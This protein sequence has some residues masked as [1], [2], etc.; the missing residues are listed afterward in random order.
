[1]GSQIPCNGNENMPTLLAVAPLVRLP[2]ARLEHLVGMDACVLPE[3]RPRKGRDQCVG[4]MTQRKVTGNQVRRRTD[5]LLAVKGVEDRSEDVFGTDR[6]VIEPL[7][8]LAGWRR[9]RDIQ[10][11]GEIER[12]CPMEEA[13][14]DLDGVR[15][16]GAN[17][18]ES[19]MNGV[20]VGEDVV[21]SFPI[22]MLVGGAEARHSE[23][24]RISERSTEVGRRG[25][26]SRRS[27]ERINCRSRIVAEKALGQRHVI[28]PDTRFLAAGSEEVRQLQA[29]PL[30]QSNEVDGLAPRRPFLSTPSCRHL[31]DHAR[32]HL[33]R[34]LALAACDGSTPSSSKSMAGRPA[35]YGTHASERSQVID[36]Y[37]SVPHRPNRTAWWGRPLPIMGARW[38]DRFRRFPASSIDPAAVATCSKAANRSRRF[39]AD[40]V[41]ERRY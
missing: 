33:G 20:R 13:A 24:R 26:V 1:M 6:Q 19:L 32:Q 16:A 17:P 9:R 15:R 4:R 10:V 28:Q 40:L 39:V 30:A 7:A 14:R 29:R 36:S 12:H 41:V 11:P 35:S 27:G 3:Q 37:R 34:M 25:P 31:A 8:V 5:L 23:C 18:L 21:G 2:H 22:R 38:N